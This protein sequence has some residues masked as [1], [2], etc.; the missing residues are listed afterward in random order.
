M[1]NTSETLATLSYTYNLPKL[2]VDSISNFM[3]TVYGRI[4]ELLEIEWTYVYE[5]MLIIQI[6]FSGMGANISC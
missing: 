4:F 2:L 3:F 5:N 1:Y 6:F